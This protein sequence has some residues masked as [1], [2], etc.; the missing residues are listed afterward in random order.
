M[1]KAIGLLDV[2]ANVSYFKKKSIDLNLILRV[3]FN[4]ENLGRGLHDKLTSSV[5]GGSIVG[6]LFERRIV[7]G[8]QNVVG[9]FLPFHRI[10][11]MSVRNY[12][13]LYTNISFT[14]C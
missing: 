9:R 11:L 13:R 5:S 3:S 8:L 6:H 14:D 10:M 12:R 1:N 7:H 2:C 4:F